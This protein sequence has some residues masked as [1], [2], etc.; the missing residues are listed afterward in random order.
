M[1][2]PEF[3]SD[4]YPTEAT[5]QK[6]R[7]WPIERAGEGL[8]FMEKAW[9]YPDCVTHVLR[10]AEA[11]V[12]QIY[13]SREYWRFATGGWSGNESLVNAFMKS[14]AAMITWALNARGGLWIF[15]EIPTSW[16]EMF[17]LMGHL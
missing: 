10:P 16:S 6:L 7:E 14:P 8:A 5:L 4:G 3:D 11:A 9:N 15:E 12:V 17:T 2:E 1:M 13:P